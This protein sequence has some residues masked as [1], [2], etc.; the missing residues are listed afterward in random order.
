MPKTTTTA[1]TTINDVTYRSRYL[2]LKINF[3]MLI[4]IGKDSDE[5]NKYCFSMTNYDLGESK[6]LSKVYA[7]SYVPVKEK[8][9]DVVSD[10]LDTFID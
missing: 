9:M 4:P 8:L 6:I 2:E 3:E 1:K 10:Y 7:D 5:P